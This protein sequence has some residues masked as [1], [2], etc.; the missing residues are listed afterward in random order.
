LKISASVAGVG[1]MRAGWCAYR[2]PAFLNPFNPYHR[3]GFI[4]RKTFEVI[5]R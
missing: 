3:A 4:A 1:V 2:N 5:T